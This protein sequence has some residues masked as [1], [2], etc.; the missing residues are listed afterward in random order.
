MIRFRKG[1]D[2]L[3]MQ[4]KSVTNQAVSEPRNQDNTPASLEWWERPARYCRE[5]LDETEIEQINSG[6]ASRLYQ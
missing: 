1:G 2:S 6:G 3:E 4:K 5:S